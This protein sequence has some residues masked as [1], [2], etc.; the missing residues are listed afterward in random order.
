MHAPPRLHELCRPNMRT[1]VDGLFDM[2]RDMRAYKSHVRDFLISVLVRA[3]ARRRG[4]AARIRVGSNLRT[5]LASALVPPRG[6]GDWRI[7][8]HG[9]QRLVCGGAHH[10]RH[11][12]CRG[13]G[14][15]RPCRAGCGQPVQPV[16]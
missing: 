11:G 8:R 5:P 3:A 2:R 14:G 7:R 4:G 10:G 9:P 16:V 6:A 15:A 12:S 1:F 13:G